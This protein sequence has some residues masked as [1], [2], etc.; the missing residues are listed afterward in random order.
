MRKNRS[1]ALLSAGVVIAAIVVGA[2]FLTTGKASPTGK[3][4]NF[5]PPTG[6][7]EATA[8][9]TALSTGSASPIPQGAPLTLTATVTPAA[10][11]GTVQ[12]KDGSTNIGSPV[13][14]VN[15]TAP[16][17]TSTL[18]VGPH[19]LTAVFTPADPAS[20]SPSTSP[21]VPFVISG[22][23]AT[24]TVLSTSAASPL[25]QAIP[26][27]LTATVTPATATGT[28]QF[29]DGSTN[30]GAPA[31]VTNGTAST[32][33][34]LAVGSHQLTAVFTP[35]NAALYSPSTSPA[36]PFVIS[37][38]T[39]T[40]TML[41]TTSAAT[42]AV[43]GTTVTLTAMVTPAAAAGTVQFMDAA[44]NFGAAV[45]VATGTASQTTTTLTAGS[46][47]LIAVFTPTTA[48]LYSAST[49]PAV[50]FVIAG[51]T[52]TS[53]TLAMSPTSSVVENTPI[54]MTATVTPTTAVGTVQFRDGNTNVDGP[55]TVTNGTAVRNGT[56]GVGT[57][58][59]TAVFTPTNSAVYVASTSRSMTYRV[60]SRPA[61]GAAAAVVPGG[62]DPPGDRGPRPRGRDGLI[63]GL[64]AGA[65][66]AIAGSAVLL[67]RRRR[68][69]RT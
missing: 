4:F 44:T 58:Q 37:G 32:A 31:A 1:L 27:T 67:V 34:T 52:T 11:T 46:H 30:V 2:A 25:A 54:S 33:S 68:R 50:T 47:Q 8:T 20:Y 36:V 29:K 22:A 13:S 10:A 48:T 39:A 28:V 38:A 43:V 35:S 9:S 60:N 42:P 41:T 62:Q 14:V 17:T 12:F 5:V 69:A 55:V 15:G 51:A 63:P 53:N 56:L 23:T 16:E 64:G 19:Q 66:P 24:S 49:S 57:H 18:A 7:R 59:L 61:L 65:A 45:A 40:S 21:A 6:S 26:L 3:V